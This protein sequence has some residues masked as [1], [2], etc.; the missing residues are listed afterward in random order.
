MKLLAY[1]IGGQTIGIDIGVWD[2]DM[3]S[4]NT[5]FL[6]IA[7]GGTIPTDYVD[8]S[9]TAYWDQFGGNTTLDAAEIKNEIIK[10]IPD[11]PTAQ[12]YE[13]LE[14]YMNVGINSTTNI[15]ENLTFGSILTNGFL[16]GVTDTKLATTGETSTGSVLKVWEV[17][18]ST[19]KFNDVLRINGKFYAEWIKNIRTASRALV[20]RYDET[21]PLTN[22]NLG[23]MVIL[24]P[25]GG[26][27]FTGGSATEYWIGVDRSG[28]TRAG[29]DGDFKPLLVGGSSGRIQLVDSV[30]GQDLNPIS[31]TPLTWGQTDFKDT[32]VFTFTNGNSN[33]T[34]LRDGMY[35]L[36]FNVN[37][38]S[39]GSNR[40]IPGVQFRNN[41]TSIAP[42][43]TSDYGRNTSNDDT[44]N[45]LAPYLINLD[46][47]DVLDVVAFRL[48]DA[49][50]NLSKAGT[51]FVRVTYLG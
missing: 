28:V 13:I 4:G 46:A 20:T 35:E 9:S 11:E 8:I 51:S 19:G 34:V 50:A 25:S 16:S 43:L 29:F 33:I 12:E 38:G 30:G 21:D 1:T 48:G 7:D 31:A 5:A 6:A 49:T 36:S 45:S 3:L 14:G 18:G 44:N 23:G 2:D 26:L 47:N 40:V 41:G 42:T 27:P 17:T 39:G 37:G 24:N 15:D 32:D 10:L 22:D